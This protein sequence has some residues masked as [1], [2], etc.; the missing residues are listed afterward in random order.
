MSDLLNFRDSAMARGALASYVR[1]A[2]V[3]GWCERWLLVATL[4]VHKGR[5]QGVHKE[6][7]EFPRNTPCEAPSRETLPKKRS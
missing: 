2:G 5:A 4:R 3:H 7:P 6:A 1:Y